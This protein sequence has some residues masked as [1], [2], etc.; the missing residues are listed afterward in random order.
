MCEHRHKQQA[1]HNKKLLALS[2]E[3]EKPLFNVKNTVICYELDR[4]PPK[5]VMET[6]S[7]GPKNAVMD[8]F[9]PKDMLT[10]LDLF[11]EYCE[12]K[13]IPQDVITDINV[14]TLD[15]IK[16]CKKLKSSRNIKLT[17]TYL[18]QNDL[19][20]VPFDKG[21]G[22]C[23]M[24]RDTYNSK[25]NDILNLP[26]FT[27]YTKERKNAKH[28]IFKEE[29]KVQ[30]LLSDL[31]K[32]DKISKVLHDKMRPRGSQPPRL[33]GLAK[34]HKTATPLRPVLSMP[35]SA[36]FNVARQVAYWLSNVPEC[37]INSSTKSICDSLKEV[38]LEDDEELVSFDVV[39]LYTNV[40]V[41]EAIQIA[42]DLLYNGT[43]TFPPID[44]ETFIKLAEISSCD[45]IMLTSNGLYR[46]TDG[47]AMGSPPAPHLANAWMSQFDGP[48]KGDSKLY[49]RYLDDMCCDKK[50]KD[51]E[52]NLA[53]VNNLHPSLKVTMEREE[54]GALPQLDMKIM[55]ENL[56][57]PGIS[58]PV[59][60]V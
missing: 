60:L 37:Q 33:Y 23:L 52:K 24:K 29:E 42:A 49:S 4:E 54:N 35:G 58:N 57:Q 18:Q 34:V 3:Q 43:N 38:H 41:K 32:E 46:Q 8:P 21:I 53:E 30:K 26:Q 55:V 9:D 25:M 39:S 40:P 45:V 56:R 10:E 48:I 51:S 12:K 22:I 14:K 59:T 2:E 15:Y 28:P 44:K 31:L 20:A 13:Y 19:L 6:L 50:R 47:L 5:Y 36:Y 1:T 27:P 16:K 11:I 17:K 7:L